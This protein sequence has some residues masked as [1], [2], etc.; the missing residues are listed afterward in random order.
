[1]VAGTAAPV[2]AL[3]QIVALPEL[4][5][6]FISAVADDGGGSF[7]ARLVYATRMLTAGVL[8]T[9]GILNLVAQGIVLSWAL[10]SLADTRDVAPLRSAIQA[11]VVGVFYLAS[12]V[13]VLAV[14]KASMEVVK[15]R[16]SRSQASDDE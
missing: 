8:I 11:T 16:K 12:G 5:N 15:A 13:F 10:E 1:M 9:F 3:A 7:R 2:I 4:L 6:Y 14:R